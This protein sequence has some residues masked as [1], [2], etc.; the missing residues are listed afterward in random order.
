M[1]TLAGGL[2]GTW[3]GIDQQIAFADKSVPKVV[4]ARWGAFSD[5]ALWAAAAFG[6][7]AVSLFLLSTSVVRKIKR[8][9][10][11]A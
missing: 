1:F 4:L 7:V 5:V 3:F 10:D 9:T 6:L 2:L 8:E 11:H